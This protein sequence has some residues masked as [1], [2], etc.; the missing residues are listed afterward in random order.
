[1]ETGSWIANRAYEM[2]LFSDFNEDVESHFKTLKIKH[3]DINGNK[4]DLRTEKG[5]QV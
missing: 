5:L 4:G 2:Y 1:M 3:P